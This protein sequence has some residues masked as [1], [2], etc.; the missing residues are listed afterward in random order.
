MKRLNKEQILLLH[1]QLIHQ[2]GG[3][4]GVR[5]FQFVGV[6]HR[7]SVSSIWRRRVISN[8]SSKRYAPGLWLNKESLY[9]GWKQ[10]NR[11]TCDASIL[12]LKWN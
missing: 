2:T 8:D 7:D 11:N 10:T 5:D 9:A 4:A 3:T 6:C 12:C 1:S